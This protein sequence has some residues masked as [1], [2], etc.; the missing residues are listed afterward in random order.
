MCDSLHTLDRANRWG[1]WKGT[2][3][4]KPNSCKWLQQLKKPGG[5]YLF[6][7]SNSSR[8]ESIHTDNKIRPYRDT[9]NYCRSIYKN[10]IALFLHSDFENEKDD[11]KLENPD[12]RLKENLL[13]HIFYTLSNMACMSCPVYVNLAF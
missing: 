8:D 7:T 1:W 2:C 4:G 12:S 5:S 13:W 9:K 3:W 10:W 6:I 11:K